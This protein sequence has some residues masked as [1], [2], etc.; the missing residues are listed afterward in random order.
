M[1]NPGQAHL[2]VIRAQIQAVPAELETFGPRAQAIRDAGDL[3]AV[4]EEARALC[5]RLRDW[6]VVYEVQEALCSEAVR[7]EE[8]AL[9]KA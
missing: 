4:E 1:D 3:E 2:E 6:L 7:A 9:V 5:G 8:E